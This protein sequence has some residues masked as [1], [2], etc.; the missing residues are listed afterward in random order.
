LSEYLPRFNFKIA[1]V[2]MALITRLEKITMDRNAH[3][4]EVEC[5]YS[6]INGD[7]GE[8]FLQIDTYGSKERQIPGKKSQS[9]RFSADAVEQLK[10]IIQEL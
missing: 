4:E 1:E 10:Q 5:T 9:L 8:R 6:I 3:H 7:N 2:K